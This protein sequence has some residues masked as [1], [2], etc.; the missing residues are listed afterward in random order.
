[1]ADELLFAG[2]A[3]R[4]GAPFKIVFWG[5]GDTKREMEFLAGLSRTTGRQCISYLNPENDVAPAAAA[6]AWNP[7][8]DSC[9]PIIYQ[10]YDPY[11]ARAG[12]TQN[13]ADLMTNP[14]VV[15]AINYQILAPSPESMLKTLQALAFMC[16]RTNP[17]FHQL[18]NGNVRITTVAAERAELY[19]RYTLQ[20]RLP[21]GYQELLDKQ[22]ASANEALIKQ[23][24]SQMYQARHGGSISWRSAKDVEKARECL[25]AGEQMLDGLETLLRGGARA[26][27]VDVCSL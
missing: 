5:C 23:S 24:I 27:F 20:R 10:L 11:E 12:V 7:Y 4:A 18:A 21:A 3:K 25:H 16:A 1:M 26:T 9:S 8:A 14:D 22:D 2:V 6:A 17:P 13:S 19:K 15:V